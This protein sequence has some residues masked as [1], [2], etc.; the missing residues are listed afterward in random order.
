MPG[1]S[2]VINVAHFT[3][4]GHER[5]VNS[6]EYS[7]SGDKPYL[8]SGSDD[9]TVRIW[10]YQTRQCLQVLT[11]HTKNVSHAIFHPFLPLIISAGEDG[12]LHVW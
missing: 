4:T 3:L 5:G 10:D 6:I 9:T 2:D 12:Q 7:T 8:L 11:G 1:T